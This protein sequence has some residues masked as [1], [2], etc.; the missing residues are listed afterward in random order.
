MI[1]LAAVLIILLLIPIAFIWIVFLRPL[2]R[3][4]GRVTLTGLSAPVQVL[5]DRWGIPHV[6]A[7]SE[8]DLFVAQGFLHAQDRLWQMDFFR[9]IGCG[10]MSEIFGAK[11]LEWDKLYRRIG[12]RRAA[13]LEVESLS[14][15]SRSA[16]EAYATGV[17]HYIAA[18]RR[19]LPAEFQI[20]R[21]KPTPWTPVDTVT[22]SKTLEW[23]MSGNAEN[24]LIRQRFASFLGDELAADIEPG[25]RAD[26]P[27]HVAANS[28]I[29]DLTNIGGSNAWAVSGSRSETGHPLLASDPHVPLTTPG[30][31]HQMHLCCDTFES[32][33]ATIPGIPGVIVGH[34]RDIA[35][36]V[37]LSFVDVQ[38]VYIEKPN[39]GN[40]QQ[41]E[42]RGEW[43]TAETVVEPIPVRGWSQPHK[44]RTIITRHGPVMTDSFPDEERPIAF[45][46]VGHPGGELMLAILRLNRARNWQEFSEAMRTWTGASM[47]F[48][49]ADRSG[50]I[51]YRLA[52]RIPVR[53]P[54]SSRFP[55]EG[56]TGEREW[57]G[58][59]P[60]D[61]MPYAFNPETGHFFSANHRIV[62][63]GYP[64]DLGGDYANGYRAQRIQDLLQAEP[65]LSADIFRRMQLDLHSIPGQE[66][67]SRYR[68]VESSDA[69]VQRAVEEL[70]NW[71]GHHTADSV[72]GTIYEVVQLRLLDEIFGVHLR[73][74]AD[75]YRGQGLAAFGGL[76][77]YGGRNILALRRVLDNPDAY[78]WNDPKTGERRTRDQVL[79]RC[80]EKAVRELQERLGSDIRRWQWGR[81]HQATFPHAFHPVKFLRRVFSPRAVPLGGDKD[82]LAQAGFSPITPYEVR[83]SGVSYRQIIDLGNWDN[84]RAVCVPGQSGHR[85]SHHYADLLK[86]W[87]RG[88]Y[89]P[90]VFSWEE[91]EKVTR[92]RLMLEPD[93]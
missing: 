44:L 9:R 34:N 70:V 36:G 92:S 42:F 55:K 58:L 48:V 56:W 46:W 67:A 26:H 71:D 22:W 68:G 89:H 27:I 18:H 13:Q 39:P 1:W 16:L 3:L 53:K 4:N 17:N 43:E 91:V 30:L 10:L 47:N 77:Q 23:L 32:T 84:C 35:W 90:M 24:E 19:K 88:E 38:D 87:R 40:S 76:N 15:D 78:W 64:Y 28:F 83:G 12:I 82:T 72:A 57:N 65:V 52:G 62:D 21:Y 29:A 8:R 11:S 74:L 79:L 86:L 51:G 85:A 50:N 33:G 6:R 41:F 81:L 60:F 75:N 54:C 69:L 25:Y 7:E 73:H 59:I 20:L 45:Q 5:H 66:L 31:W 93:P 37:T 80:M 49:Y 14:E 2:P 61:E 63:D